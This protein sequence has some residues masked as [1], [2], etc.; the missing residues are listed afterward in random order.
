MKNRENYFWIQIILTL[1]LE[2]EAHNDF[3][4]HFY[5][6]KCPGNK[7]H[8]VLFKHTHSLLTSKNIDETASYA[9]RSI[10]PTSNETEEKY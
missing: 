5:S 8:G 2:N 10:I 9:V 3:D 7:K 1:I 6:Y 4:E